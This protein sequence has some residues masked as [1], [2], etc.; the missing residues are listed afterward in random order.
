MAQSNNKSI[1]S[2]DSMTDV[3]ATDKVLVNNNGTLK[4]VT[5][6]ALLKNETDSKCK[7]VND[8]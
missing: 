8:W 7:G 5:V 6:E 4:Q 1:L 3:G 2:V